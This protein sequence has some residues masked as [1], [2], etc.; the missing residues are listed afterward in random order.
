MPVPKGVGYKINESPRGKTN[1]VVF[2]QVRHK[3][4]CT[5]TGKSYKLEISDLSRRGIGLSE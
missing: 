1:N 4:T 3:P 5:V 2:D